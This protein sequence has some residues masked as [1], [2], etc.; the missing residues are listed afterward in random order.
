MG[1]AATSGTGTGAG[2]CIAGTSLGGASLLA[3]PT[4]SQL[5]AVQSPRAARE[6]RVSRFTASDG[7]LTWIG[8]GLGL[9]LGLRSG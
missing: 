3:T 6:V 7:S 4:A 2:A 9:G 8:L 5:A 1:A